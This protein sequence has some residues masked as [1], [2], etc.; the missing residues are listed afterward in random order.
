MRKVLFAA[1]VILG[2]PVPAMADFQAGKEA[3]AHGDYA[4]AM[5]EWLPL[6]ERGDATAQY[7]LGLLYGNGQGVAKNYEEAYFWFV[8]ASAYGVQAGDLGREVTHNFLNPDQ[9]IA[10]RKRVSEWRPK[11]T[12]PPSPAPAASPK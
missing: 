3:Y 5:Q 9:I 11:P 6:A 10:I 7:N 12:V 1:A 2:M 4:M 8:L